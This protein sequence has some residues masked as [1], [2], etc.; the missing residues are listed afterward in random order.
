LKKASADGRKIV[1]DLKRQIGNAKIE[2]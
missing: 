1:T 2:Y